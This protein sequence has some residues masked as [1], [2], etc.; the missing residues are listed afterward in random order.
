MDILERRELSPSERSDK[1]R[2]AEAEARA[3]AEARASDM[4]HDFTR[5]FATKP[6]RRV[7]AW[8]KERCGFGQIILSADRQSGKIDPMLTTFAAMELNLYLEIRR[9]LPT[10]LVQEIEDDRRTAPTGTIHDP[11][12]GK[13]VERVSRRRTRG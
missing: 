4:R 12:T 8:L 10:E 1:Q 13:P 2:E 3:R 7:L 11:A 5:T 9:H 6:G